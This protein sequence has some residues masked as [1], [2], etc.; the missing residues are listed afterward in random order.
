MCFD[1]TVQVVVEPLEVY[2]ALVA[3]LQPDH[4]RRE[5]LH[6][7]SGISCFTI[8]AAATLVLVVMAVS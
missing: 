6:K 1:Q 4:P 5:Q 2:H 7:R 3:Q 8:I